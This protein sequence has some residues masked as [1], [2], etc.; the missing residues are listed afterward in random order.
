MLTRGDHT[1][2][3]IRGSYPFTVKQMGPYKVTSGA[4]RS[5]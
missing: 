3:K 5:S 4:E 2:H 1:Q